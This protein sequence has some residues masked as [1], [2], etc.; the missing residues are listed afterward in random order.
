LVWPS[1]EPQLKS[2]ITAT[3]CI[4][5]KININENHFILLEF[6]EKFDSATRNSRRERETC[7]DGCNQ[8]YQS[9]EFGLASNLASNKSN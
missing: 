2:I 7:D 4:M 8:S 6:S 3:D 1:V 5:L 9:S